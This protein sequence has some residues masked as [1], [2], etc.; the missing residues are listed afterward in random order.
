MAKK[1]LHQT[2]DEVQQILDAIQEGKA[3]ARYGTSADWDAAIGFVPM[4]G[5]IIVYT[6]YKTTI[7]NG[8]RVDV[9]GIKI[10][11]GNG[12]VQDLVFVG[13]A[14]ANTLAAHI[15]N[16]NI[17]TTQYEKYTWDRK[18]NVNDAQEVVGESLILNR[19]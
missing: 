12:Y 3:I 4:A 16:T 19:N 15:A 17:H 14:D 9:P 6:D 1:R 5:E 8:V 11:S 13:E 10:G 7:V 18:L 2:F